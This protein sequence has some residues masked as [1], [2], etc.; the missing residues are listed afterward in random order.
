[1]PNGLSPPTPLFSRADL[2]EGGRRT[3]AMSAA[4]IVFG[5]IFGAAA[6]T[7]GLGAVEAIFMSAT[8]FAASAQFTALTLWADP[9]PIAA[10]VVAAV[11]IT[12]RLALFS[13]SL[14][15]DMR[16]ASLP[17]RLAALT[18]VSDYPWAASRNADASQ[19]RAALYLGSALCMYSAWVAGTA[20]GAFGA[21]IVPV[22]LLTAFSFAGPL[23]LIFVIVPIL[24]QKRDAIIPACIAGATAIALDGVA[25]A[26]AIVPAAVT[27]SG[28]VALILLRP[29]T[30]GH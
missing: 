26:S 29:R 19:S 8:V 17:K 30:H 5:L 10:I 18:I 9:P 3:I 22:D 21:D 12:S 25:P 4:V 11:L 20:L 24:R 23:F 2:L 6:V 13:T 1:M 7:A 16:G 28:A 27:A 15:A 14:A